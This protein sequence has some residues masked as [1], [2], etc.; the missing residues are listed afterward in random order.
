MKRTVQIRRPTHRP[1][2]DTKLRRSR[3]CK[4]CGQGYFWHVRIPSTHPLRCTHC[5]GKFLTQIEIQDF[6]HDI[7]SIREHINSCDK[8][9]KEKK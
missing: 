8:F 5:H 4:E 9:L 3:V 7:L 2:L 6:G 1:G